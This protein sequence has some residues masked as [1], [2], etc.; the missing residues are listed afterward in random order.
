MGLPGRGVCPAR[1][2][3]ALQQPAL[4]QEPQ[5]PRLPPRGQLPAERPG[6]AGGPARGL[7]DELRPL[8]GARGLLETHLVGGA[9]PVRVARLRSPA[10]VLARGWLRSSDGGQRL[11]GRAGTAHTKG[12]G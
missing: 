1:Q 2:H 10:L 3:R 6:T 11:A 4:R 9:A 12:D 5:Q 8:A 7:P